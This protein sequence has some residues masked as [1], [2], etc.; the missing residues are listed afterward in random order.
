MAAPYWSPANLYGQQG[1]GISRGDTESSGDRPKRRRRGKAYEEEEEEELEYDSD[2]ETEEEEDE[3]EIEYQES[4]EEDEEAPRRA[5]PPPRGGKRKREPG[6][7]PPPPA[8]APPPGWGRPAGAPAPPWAGAA[9]GGQPY[10]H[11]PPPQ[12]AAAAAPAAGQPGAYGGLAGQL[13]RRGY[14]LA[15]AAA[16]PGSRASSGAAGGAGASASRGGGASYRGGGGSDTEDEDDEVEKKRQRKIPP[17]LMSAEQ[18]AELDDEVERV[19]KHRDAEGVPL[20]PVRPW[21]T[22]EFYVKWARYSH[23]H[24]SWDSQATLSQLPG[25]KRVLNYIKKCEEEARARPYL[26]AEEAELRDVQKAMEEELVIE[27]CQVEKVLAERVS[28]EGQLQYLCKWRGCPYVEATYEPYEELLKVEGAAAAIE[29]FQE[30]EARLPDPRASVEGARRAFAQV[31]GLNWMVYCW[32]RG[33][34][35]ILADEMA[36]GAGAGEAAGG[37]G[38]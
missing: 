30:R 35:A 21:R 3:D 5:P 8:A 34:N 10:H 28:A 33:T 7:V 32:S 26:T 19:I 17:V 36:R 9:G 38:S 12:A 29:E 37:G 27:F 15:S 14:Q 25:Y 20:D 22:R 16:A 11:H 18:L 6:P 24:C 1:Q 13:A 2:E 23:L 31:E 4:D